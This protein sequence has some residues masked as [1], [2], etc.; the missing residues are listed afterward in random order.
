MCIRDRYRMFT[1]RSEYR[2]LLRADN[3]DLRLT[4]LGIDIGCV[5]I[6]RQREFEKK[7]S[8]IRKGFSFVKSQKFSPDALLKKGIKINKDGKKRNIIDLLSFSNI[9]TPK[10]KKILPELNDLEDDVIEQIEIEAKYAGYLDRQRMD[11]QDFEKEESLKIPKSTNY[12]LV[13]SLSNEIVEKLSK[14]KPPTL[15]AASRISGV[16]PAATI[17][18]LRYIKKNKNKKAA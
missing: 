1:S 9:T 14:I 11:I 5:D 15:G 16:T 13:G 10:L 3:A 4:P 12:K 8:R 18:L 7:S 6:Y 17:A 2:L